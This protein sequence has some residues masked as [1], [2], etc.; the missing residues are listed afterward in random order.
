MVVQPQ[1]LTR[2]FCLGNI[3]YERL[4]SRNLLVSRGMLNLIPRTSFWWFML[5]A[6][7]MAATPPL[8]LLGELA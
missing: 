8:N 5:S 7:N 6:C 4:D 1:S 2:L 3:S